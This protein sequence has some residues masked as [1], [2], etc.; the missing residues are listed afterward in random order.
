MASS[1]LNLVKPPPPPSPRSLLSEDERAAKDAAA[2]VVPLHEL[3][4]LFEQ[5][6]TADDSELLQVMRVFPG[7]AS[8]ERLRRQAERRLLCSDGLLLAVHG[9]RIT[10]VVDALVSSLP[11]TEHEKRHGLKARARP[12]PPPPPPPPHPARAAA[13]CASHPHQHPAA[14]SRAPPPRRSCSGWTEAQGDG[15]VLLDQQGRADHGRHDAMGARPPARAQARQ[16]TQHAREVAG[17][18]RPRPTTAR[19][20][21]GR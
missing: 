14:P 5:L 20:C 9:N 15:A 16:G 8:H 10:R 19:A 11:E 7:R 12:S 3:R 6:L 13:C 1:S 17:A 18:P 21:R 4:A 2:R